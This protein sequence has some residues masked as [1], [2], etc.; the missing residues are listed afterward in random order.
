MGFRLIGDDDEDEDEIFW[1]ERA[2]TVCPQEAGAWSAG[3]SL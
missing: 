1:V 2:V 3:V